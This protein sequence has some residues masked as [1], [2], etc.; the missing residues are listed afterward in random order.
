MSDAHKIA[1]PAWIREFVLAGNATFTLRSVRT[2]TRFTY[3]VRKTRADAPWFVSVL[4]GNDNEHAYTYLGTIHQRNEAYRH[5]VKSPLAYD[6]PSAKAFAWFWPHLEEC[7]RRQRGEL[8]PNLEVWHEGRCGR[9]GRKLTVPESIA[10]GLGPECAKRRGLVQRPEYDDERE[11][12]LDQLH[13]IDGWG[14]S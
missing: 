5:G 12:E 11:R 2:G 13:G 4:T 7:F 1:D 3:R 10:S 14:G 6:A 8:G 9:C